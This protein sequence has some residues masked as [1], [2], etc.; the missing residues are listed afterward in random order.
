MP[1]K[2][3]QRQLAREK[4]QRQMAKRAEAARRRRRAQ[5]VTGSALAV[6]AVIAVAGF[7]IAKL[8][9]GG[10]K[11][12]ASANVAVCLYPKSTGSAARKVTIPP[13]TGA[14]KG[15]AKVAITTNQGDLTLTLNR[16]KAPCTVNSFISLVKQKYFD[17]TPC[18]RLTTSGI[19]V[20]QCGDPSGTGG[21]GPGYQFAEEGLP[22]GGG[23]GI[24][25]PAGTVA[26]ANAGPGTN[27]SQFFLV[28]KDTSLPPNYTMFGT[29]S[30][31]QDALLAIAKAGAVGPTGKPIAD[32]KPK[33]PVTI[34][35]VKLA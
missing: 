18:H 33:K 29:I 13:L 28:Y 24:T 34:T 14:K 16:A 19:F 11:P 17:N 2:D 3:R 12:K 6:V 27:G 4:L 26:M 10:K 9:H 20:L 5:A 30:G 8:S 23:T 22:A 1:G 25:Y 7:G 35:A 32:G 21:G 31:G 15:T